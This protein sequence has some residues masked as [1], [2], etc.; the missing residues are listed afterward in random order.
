MLALIL[1][2]A[3]ALLLLAYFTY[4]RLVANF[5]RLDCEAPTP[6]VLLSDRLDY[7]PTNKFYLLAQH[8]SAIS[9]A[10]PIFGPI[11]AGLA[12]GWLPALLWIVGG[13]V[14]IGAVH[15]FSTLVASL[16]H[17]GASIAEVVRANTSPRAFY[18]FMAYIWFTLVYVLS[19][20]TDVTAR[21]LVNN[22]ELKDATGQ[23]VSTALGSGT[24]TSSILYLS[25]GLL[26]GV[27]FKILDQTVGEAAWPWVRR[28][29]IGVFMV[30]VGA[31]IVVGQSFPVQLPAVVDLLPF[32]IGNPAWAD[33]AVSWGYVI[34]A[35]C[36][37]ASLLPVWLLL[38]PR[39]LL[40]GLFLYVILIGGLVGMF[41]G[42]SQGNFPV[43]YPAFLGFTSEKLGPLFPVLFITIACG[44][45]SGFHGLVCSGTTSKQL[46]CEC[47][48]PLVGY[49]GMLLETVIALI[50]LACVMVLVPGSA[51]RPDEVFARGIGNFISA[52]GVDRSFAIGFGLLAFA[53]FV[54]DTIDVAT[55]LAR[56]LLEEIFNWR[57]N[58]GKAFATGLTLLLP[59]ILLSLTFT[60][61]DGKT[62][63]GYL[64][65]WPVFGAANQ[66]LAALSLL[67]LFVWLI[68]RKKEK[69]A[70]VFVGLPMAFMMTVTLWALGLATQK[71]FNGVTGG[72]RS[73]ADPVG[74]ISLALL[75]LAVILI[76]EGVRALFQ[77]LPEGEAL[78]S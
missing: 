51:G 27:C 26:L 73:W 23:V 53:T 20:F 41:V 40:G 47:D 65:I 44:A 78:S 7:V 59:A 38:Q 60:G 39:G 42:T 16:R 46:K 71:W 22:I 9:A 12:F 68:R 57:D 33:P 50:A 8:F 72:T 32:A 52:L 30:L 10:G 74:W 6:A 58:W 64:V 18:L 69:L 66:L 11:I 45:C 48:A 63:P 17:R 61:A 62:I 67:G 5:Y 2:V 29:L 35:Y 31:A 34:L 77:P 15:D 55:R 3:L 49:G 28:G 75:V 1:L 36:A 19:A 25:L 56:Y 24:A 37:V 21:T 70:Y 43:V 13:S 54:F 76:N 14:F 4:G